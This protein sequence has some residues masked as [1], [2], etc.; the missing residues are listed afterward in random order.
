M[1]PDCESIG[2]SHLPPVAATKAVVDSMPPR[3]L[4]CAQRGHQQV[5]GSCE[6]FDRA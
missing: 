1:P 5:P 2:L 3:W 4:E 6:R